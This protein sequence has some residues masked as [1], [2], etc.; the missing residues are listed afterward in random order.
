MEP[1]PG[2]YSR[3]S[4]PG[5]FMVMIAGQTVEDWKRLAPPN[6]ICEY[7]DGII[8]MPTTPTE[9]HQDVAGFLFMLLN[10]FRCER[11]AGPVR[12]AP[13]ALALS[14][15][16]YP[17]PDLIA[18]PPEGGEDVPALLTIEIFSPSTRVHDLTKKSPMY[19]EHAIPE[20]WFVDMEARALNVERR[21]ADGRYA[22]HRLEAGRWAVACLPG[23]WIDVTW[24]WERPLPNPLRC[25]E[26]ILAGPPA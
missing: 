20:L 17:G 14:A 8:Y 2:L 9:E 23:F 6:Q 3:A 7:I 13:M 12:F 10:G 1:A 5:D 15:E 22:I 18:Y 16:R 24:L 25:L 21:E 11:E 4:L 19:Q 26:A